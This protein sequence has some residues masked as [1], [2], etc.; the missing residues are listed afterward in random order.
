MALSGLYNAQFTMH[1][2]IAKGLKTC[3]LQCILI[4]LLLSLFLC[5]CE[6]ERVVVQG[7]SCSWGESKYSIKKVKVE[8][9][10]YDDDG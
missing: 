5:S 10:G 2:F 8:H 1:N 9:V 3:G 4:V 7:G 6:K